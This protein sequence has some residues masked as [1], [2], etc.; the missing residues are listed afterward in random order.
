MK[1][2]L[3]L[4]IPA[5]VN[6]S[7]AAQTDPEDFAFGYRIET[8]ASGAIYELT[9]PEAVYAKA[10][11]ADLGDI[12]V[13]NAAGETVPHA[14]RRAIQADPVTPAPVKLRIFPLHDDEA[15]LSQQ[16]SM[17][18][19]ADFRSA[20]IELESKPESGAEAIVAYILDVSELKQAPSRLAVNWDS[21]SD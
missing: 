15:G 21:T 5:L 4:L 11:H 1:N 2:L 12:A 14:F 17:K 10:I 8:P 16:L 19:K 20:L 18:L 3:T 9:L 7:A 13:F 6:V